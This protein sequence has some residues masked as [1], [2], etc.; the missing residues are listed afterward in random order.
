MFSHFRIL[1]VWGNF[2]L[3]AFWATSDA[4]ALTEMINFTKIPCPRIPQM[5]G[6]DC[7]CVVAIISA[8]STTVIFVV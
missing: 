4:K 8:T 2:S 5:P 3:A 1:K 6:L 7:Y